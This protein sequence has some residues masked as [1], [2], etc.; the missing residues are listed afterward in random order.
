MT[1]KTGDPRIDSPL[2]KVVYP[3]DPLAA[4]TPTATGTSVG[5][6]P[7]STET[8]QTKELFSEMGQQVSLVKTEPT[9][10]VPAPTSKVWYQGIADN[11][12]LFAGVA[13]TAL[14]IGIVIGKKL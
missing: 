1:T 8:M 10:Q 7:I 9:G 11:K 14:V 12:L 2:I 13:L 4:T 5:E 6:K 3:S